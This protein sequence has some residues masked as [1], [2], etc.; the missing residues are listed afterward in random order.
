[1]TAVPPDRGGAAH[2][3]I[4]VPTPHLRD[5][6]VY[7]TCLRAAGLAPIGVRRRW[8]RRRD[9]G[10]LAVPPRR[11]GMAMTTYDKASGMPFTDVLL[12]APGRAAPRP[13][14]E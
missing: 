8:G 5:V 9:A 14:R 6:A 12:A 10:R 2:Q 4:I 1:M 11:R 7:C 3:L 13:A